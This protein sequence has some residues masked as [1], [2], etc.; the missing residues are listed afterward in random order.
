MTEFFVYH[1]GE[2]KRFKGEAPTTLESVQAAVRSKFADVSFNNNDTVIYVQA[3]PTGVAFECEAASDVTNGA[4]LSVRSRAAL[5]A[6]A[7]ARATPPAAP[8]ATAATAAAS[9]SAASTGVS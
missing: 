8:A 5:A 9:P 7:A 4:I 2:T 1:G 3:S 6:V